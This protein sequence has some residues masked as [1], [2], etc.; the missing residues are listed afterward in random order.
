[1]VVLSEKTL[2]E[3]RQRL[4]TQT[5]LLKQKSTSLEEYRGAQ[6]AVDKYIGEVVS[7]RA[8]VTVAQAELNQTKTVVEMHNIRSPTRGVIKGILK[9]PGEGVRALETMF[10]IQPEIG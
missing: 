2:A 5:D 4:A 10:L 3:A 9:H 1:D 6:L 7:K 8:S